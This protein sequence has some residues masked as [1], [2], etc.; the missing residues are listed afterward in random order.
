LPVKELPIPIKE[1][2]EIICR[3]DAFYLWIDWLCI[4]QNDEKDVERECDRMCDIYERALLTLTAMDDDTE[5]KKLFLNRRVLDHSFSSVSEVEEQLPW[6]ARLSCTTK[7]KLL[8][9][10]YLG[11]ILYTE[12][13]A[14]E[15]NQSCFDEELCESKWITREWILQERLPSRRIVYFGKRQLYWECQKKFKNEDGF[16]SFSDD[17]V[18]YQSAGFT[19]GPRDSLC[20]VGR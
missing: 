19:E 13:G 6:R 4:V 2:I 20:Q 3:I 10:V 7:D 17:L 9:H 11:R 12:R 8:G 14:Q 18:N 5:E 1:I 15:R 16:S